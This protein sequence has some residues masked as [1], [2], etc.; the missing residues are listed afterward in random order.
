V[1]KLR[2]DTAIA[3]SHVRLLG[4][5]ISLDLSVDRHVSRVMSV[6][7]A[8]TD[9]VNSGVSGGRWTLTRWPRSSMLL[10]PATNEPSCP[11]VLP[12][13]AT[14]LVCRGTRAAQIFR[15]KSIALQ[16]SFVARPGKSAR[17]SRHPCS[18]AEHTT[19]FS[20]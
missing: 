17:A 19:L 11:A 10:K 6:R 13:R 18:P 8:F 1:L 7:A 4:V 5:D 3:G 20:F 15:Q 16:C 12:G 14:R 2:A 9:C